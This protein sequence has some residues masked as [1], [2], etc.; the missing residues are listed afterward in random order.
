MTKDQYILLYEKYKKGTCTP[1]EQRNLMAYNDE[2]NL[3][4]VPWDDNIGVDQEEMRKKIFSRL[5]RHVLSKAKIRTLSITKWAAASIVFFIIS[6]SL[7]HIL[8]RP[9]PSHLVQNSEKHFKDN[10]LPGTNK[11]ILRLGSGKVVVLNDAKNGVLAYESNVKIKKTANG[12]VTY[13]PTTSTGNAINLNNNTITTPRG[14][15]YQLILPDGTKVWLNSAS[16]LSFPDVFAGTERDV[17]LT[18]EA[19]FEVAKN[20]KMPFKIS[21]NNI[22]VEVV[23]THFDIM[24][25]N[26]EDNIK[27]TLMEGSVKI[28]ASNVNALLKPGQQAIFDKLKNNINVG[29]VNTADAIAWKNGYFVFD[30]ENIQEVMRK[31][32]RWYNV[33]ID[34]SK[35]IPDDH[36]EGSITHFVNVSKVLDMLELTGEVHFIIKERRITVTK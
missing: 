28:S 22:K 34:Y 9:K 29:Y 31:I 6:F 18:G 12:Q 13:S 14:G 27:T 5:E 4:D 24:A 8:N 33:D 10:I 25:Y 23:G 36:F 11:A 35:D 2:F 16:S 30:R 15:Q 20:K 1:D 7:Y 17:K 21:V 19:Y 32:A 3:L 26:D